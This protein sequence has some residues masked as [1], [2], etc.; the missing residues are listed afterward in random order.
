MTLRN[1]IETDQAKLQIAKALPKHID[2]EKFVRCVVTCLDKTPKL[3]NCTSES[4][5]VAMLD[6]ASLGLLPNGRDAHLIPYGD[7]A[8]FIVDYK[9]LIKL[10]FQS[11]EIS[12]IRAGVVFDGDEFDFATCD[13]VPFGWRRDADRPSERGSCIGAFCII[14]KKDGSVHRERMTF[15]EIESVRKRSRSG[16]GNSPWSTDWEE[17]AKKTVFRRASKWIQISVDVDNA[18]DRDGDRL[19]EPAT[20]EKPK[21]ATMNDSI[22]AALGES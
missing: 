20:P 9:G 8:T 22:V 16:S 14:E 1:L 6:S 13:H 10:A 4:F 19:I 17:M 5:K 12:N 21:P 3:A 18:L 7:K 15:D 2:V 11:G